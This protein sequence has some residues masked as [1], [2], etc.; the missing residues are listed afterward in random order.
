MPQPTCL[1]SA[2]GRRRHCFVRCCAPGLG[3]SP[4]RSAGFVILGVVSAIAV[5]L[6]LG[7]GLWLATRLYALAMGA[8]ASPMDNSVCLLPTIQSPRSTH[9]YL[10]L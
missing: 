5:L 2:I 1:L 3:Q 9:P 10:H 6:P 4:G 7:V 8:R